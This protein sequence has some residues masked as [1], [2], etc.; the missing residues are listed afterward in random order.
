MIDSISVTHITIE[1]KEFKRIGTFIEE[2][3][4]IRM[5]LE[6][7]QLV[8]AR[9]QKRL[10][11][12]NF[13]S[14]GQYC[15]YLFSKEGLR[16]ELTN[17]ID[18][19]TTNKTDFFREPSH[20]DFLQSVALIDLVDVRKR[21]SLEIWSTAS[22]T[23]EEPYTI[24]MVCELFAR[25]SP[26]FSYSILATDIS[27]EVL[28]KGRQ[29]VYPEEKTETVP[30]SYRKQFLLRSK[31]HNRAQVRIKPF[32]R[33]RVHFKKVNLMEENYHIPKRFDIIFC[34]NVLIYFDKSNQRRIMTRIYKLLSPGGYLFMGHSESMVT[35]FLPLTTVASTIYRKMENMR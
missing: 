23:G 16:R 28:E 17:L 21:S 13:Q 26:R 31:D 4:G 14:F 34:R 35:T 11:A 25:N 33:S 15:D 7:K 3:F 6:K 9:L 24:A 27:S 18:A 1:G 5:P 32:L 19:I 30:L 10:R 8:E 20:F 2:E 12:L 29:A 22:S